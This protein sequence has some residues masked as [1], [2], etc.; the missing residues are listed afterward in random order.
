MNEVNDLP[1]MART[2]I[3]PAQSS[4]APRPD[5]FVERKAFAELVGIKPST[6]TKWLRLY[7]KARLEEGLPELGPALIEKHP[8]FQ[9]FF[10]D[11]SRAAEFKAAA[12]SMRGPGGARYR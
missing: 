10:F 1:K 9:K 8:N 12:E 2:D 6:L 11:P 5:G 4:E 3:I 7:N